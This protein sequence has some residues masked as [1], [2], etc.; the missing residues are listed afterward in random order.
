LKERVSPRK[1][2]KHIAKLA[3]HYDANGN[4]HKERVVK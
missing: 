1:Y 4:W 3:A 2:Q